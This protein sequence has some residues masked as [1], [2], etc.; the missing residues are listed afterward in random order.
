MS[1][2]LLEVKVRN[3]LDIHQCLR[4]FDKVRRHGVKTESGHHFQ[5]LTASSDFDG[6]T[7]FLSSNDVTL[8]L[9]FHNK[10]DLEYR[11]HGDVDAFVKLLSVIDHAANSELVDGRV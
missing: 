8:T 1:Q 5:G 6:Y 4:V 11:Q 3:E 9:F 7:A 10:Y 2:L